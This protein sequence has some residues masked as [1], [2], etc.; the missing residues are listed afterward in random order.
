MVQTSSLGTSY[1]ARWKW[2]LKNVLKIL[3]KYFIKDY[4]GAIN[5]YDKSIDI[6]PKDANAYSD[7]GD[8]KLFL[9][10]YLGAISD[11]NTSIEI[12]DSSDTPYTTPYTGRAWA[13]YLTGDFKSAIIDSRKALTFNSEDFSA[14]ST[15]GFSQYELGN[16]KDACDNLKKAISIDKKILDDYLEQNTQEYLASKKGSWCRNMTSN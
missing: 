15:L 4:Q 1:V 2:K 9:K 6:Y 5:D 7:R 14:L 16:K 13:K 8:A 3:T 10:D 12:N 11:F